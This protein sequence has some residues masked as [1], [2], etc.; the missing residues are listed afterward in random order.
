MEIA[1]VS[2]EDKKYVKLDRDE[3]RKYVEKSK[4]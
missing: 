2:A 3:I 1:Y 4:K